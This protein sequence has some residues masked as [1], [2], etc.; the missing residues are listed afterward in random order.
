MKVIARFSESY[1][2][3]SSCSGIAQKPSMIATSAGS[4]NS[5]TRVSGLSIPVSLESTGLM[6]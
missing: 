5:C 6:Q 4:S 1:N 2:V 3:L